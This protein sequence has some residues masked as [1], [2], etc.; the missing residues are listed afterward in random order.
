MVID[1]FPAAPPDPPNLKHKTF[2]LTGDK[3]MLKRFSAVMDKIRRRLNGDL[4][5]VPEK[6]KGAKRPPKRSRSQGRKRKKR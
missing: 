4:K 1:P 6:A 3:T 2:N 5:E